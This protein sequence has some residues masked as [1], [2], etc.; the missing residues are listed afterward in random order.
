MGKKISAFGDEILASIEDTAVRM[1]G[2]C[3]RYRGAEAN[4]RGVGLNLGIWGN[5]SIHYLSRRQGTWPSP[6]FTMRHNVFC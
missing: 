5:A 6:M 3:I 2:F 1:S 4:Y